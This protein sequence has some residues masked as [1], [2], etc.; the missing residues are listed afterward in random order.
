MP[1]TTLNLYEKGSSMMYNQPPQHPQQPQ[2][3]P[4]RE[5]GGQRVPVNVSQEMRWATG[6]MYT[7]AHRF[8]ALICINCGHSSLYAQNFQDLRQGRG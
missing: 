5:C 6:I 7:S 1:H 2:I 3:P 8:S 4:C